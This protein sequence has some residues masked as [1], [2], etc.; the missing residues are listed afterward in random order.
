MLRRVQ[1]EMF[2][3]KIDSETALVGSTLE[4]WRGT[5]FSVPTSEDLKWSIKIFSGGYL[6]IIEIFK[7]RQPKREMRAFMPRGGRRPTH[8]EN[9]VNLVLVQLDS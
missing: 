6:P 4:R 8:L 7:T 2:T 3:F 1:N 9:L 5:L